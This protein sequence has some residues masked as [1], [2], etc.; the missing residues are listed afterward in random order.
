MRTFI[1]LGHLL[2]VPCGGAGTNPQIYYTKPPREMWVIY[3]LFGK[4]AQFNIVLPTV[5]CHLTSNLN[6]Y[7]RIGSY[8]NMWAV[9][10]VL[11]PSLLAGV[12]NGEAR[13]TPRGYSSKI[14]V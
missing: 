4:L 6:S 12:K 1:H 5:V 2:Q 14:D 13:A 7:T 11:L 3:T 10:S 9:W 8:F